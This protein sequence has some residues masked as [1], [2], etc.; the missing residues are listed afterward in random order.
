MDWRAWHDSYD[1]PDSRLA[2]RLRAVQG[3]IRLALD[4]APAGPLRVVSVC[5]GQGRDLLPVLAWHPR[6]SDVRARLVELDP[7]NADLARNAVALAG[8]GGVEVVTG[9]AALPEH[10]AGA[11][12]ADLV[13]L[14]GVFGNITD[15]DIA[16]TAAVAPSLCAP[17]ATV[18]WTRHREPPDRVPAICGWFEERGFH[19]EWVSEPEAG[20][21]V[22]VHRYQG[23]P[24]PLVDDGP[25][26]DFVGKSALDRAAQPLDDLGAGQLSEQLAGQRDL[27]APDA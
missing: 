5:A 9:N 3:R 21:G 2:R 16:R 17:G 25:M 24:Q 7:R 27:A 20:Y 23:P 6:G 13:L 1:D 4:T 26:F 12:P 15:A 10:Y 8:L 18:I 14:C 22:G 19:T 11:V